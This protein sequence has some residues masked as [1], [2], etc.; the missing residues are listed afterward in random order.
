MALPRRFSNAALDEWHANFNL[1]LFFNFQMR[2][3][4]KAYTGFPPVSR[5]ERRGFTIA[6]AVLEI[7]APC[8]F[9][10]DH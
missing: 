1:F 2:L 5:G 7:A 8:C 9:C 3:R 6:N 4:A 10:N